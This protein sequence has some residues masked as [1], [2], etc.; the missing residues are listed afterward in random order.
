M[1][2]YTEQY[3]MP[4]WW[5]PGTIPIRHGKCATCRKQGPLAFSS[6]HGPVCEMDCWRPKGALGGRAR[7]REQV[8][9]L[10]SEERDRQDAKWGTEEGGKEYME[11]LAILVEEVGEFAE[12]ILEGEPIER[13]EAELIQV[14]AVAMKALEFGGVRRTRVEGPVVLEAARRTVDVGMMSRRYLESRE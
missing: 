7:F 3:S 14:G 12:A 5:I 13:V 8:V 9:A 1:S 4:S 6:W 11:W 10:L 2:D